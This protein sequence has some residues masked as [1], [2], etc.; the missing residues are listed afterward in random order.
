MAFSLFHFHFDSKYSQACH[1]RL[2]HS[3][4]RSRDCVNPS[5]KCR[6][7]FLMRNL[8][9]HISRAIFFSLCLN[10]IFALI[11]TIPAN[12]RVRVQSFVMQPAQ[13]C[14]VFIFFISIIPIDQMMQLDRRISA[15]HAYLRM[16]CKILPLALF[17]QFAFDVIAIEHTY[18]K[19]R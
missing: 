8:L 14:E 11:E 4:D 18:N 5:V 16:H 3:P 6:L 10:I 12:A 2:K 1:P 9:S 13:R 19:P 17:P 15:N 7:F